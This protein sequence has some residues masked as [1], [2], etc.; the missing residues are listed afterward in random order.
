MARLDSRT[1]VLCAANDGIFYKFGEPSPPM[2]RHWR[3]R[4]TK[5]WI[6]NNPKDFGV[7]DD[8]IQRVARPWVEREKGIIGRGGS[9]KIL[10]AGTTKAFYGNWFKALSPAKQNDVVGSVR[11]ELLRNGKIQWGQLIDKTTGRLKT[12][13]DLG[14]SLSGVRK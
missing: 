14:F 13:D 5:N 8:E 9:R 1:C 12:L 11:A 6:T 4:C 7:P 2:P 10:N 3:C